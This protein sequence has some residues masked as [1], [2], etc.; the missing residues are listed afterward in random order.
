MSYDILFVPRRPGQTWESALD[1][2]EG[3][4]VLGDA[5]RPERLVQWDRVVAALRARVGD[6]VVTVDDDTCEA[7]H[8]SGLVLALYPDEASVSF[9]YRHREDAA[10]FHDVIVDVV[11]ILERET[12]LHAW[13]AQTDEPF[14]GRV[15]DEVG[16][17]ATRRLAQETSD[18]SATEAMAARADAGHVGPDTGPVPVAP[19]DPSS[20]AAGP[21]DD[22]SALLARE[23]RR[24]LVYVVTGVLIVTVALSIDGGGQPSTLGGVAIA[25]G[26]LDVVLGGLMYLGASRRSA[27]RG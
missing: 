9:P 16:L 4:D 6:V 23:R 27:A 13:D 2:A 10:A 21:V 8:P 7:T 5:V 1:E 26:V 25:I 20:P 14:D 22:S 11:G 12:G 3:R 18:V 15:H 19:V 24:S 17:A